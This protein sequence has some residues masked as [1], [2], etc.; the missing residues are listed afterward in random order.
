MADS[1]Q[2]KELT[3]RLEQGVKELFNSEAYAN[4][5]RTMARFHKYYTRN[6]LLIHMQK[7][8]ATHVAGFNAW[9]TNFNRHVKKGEK[10]IK[11]F[12]PIPLK[13]TKEMEKIDPETQRPI[14]GENG[15]PIREEI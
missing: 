6:T 11:I 14:I 1:T 10:A 4:Y 2:V 12:A 8:E 15:E 7:P 13:I 9:Q 3:S 5:L